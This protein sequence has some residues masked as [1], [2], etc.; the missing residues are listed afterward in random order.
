MIAHPIFDRSMKDIRKRNHNAGITRQSNF[1]SSFLSNSG[2]KSVEDR[3][4]TTRGSMS[5]FSMMDV[6]PAVPDG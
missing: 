6:I 2:S 5:V 4:S 3:D 1:R